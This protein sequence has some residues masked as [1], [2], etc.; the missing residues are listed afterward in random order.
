MSKW[1]KLNKEFYDKLN[2]ITDEEMIS[3]I[4]NQEQNKLKR[5][6]FLEKDIKEHLIE[7]NTFNE[8]NESIHLSIGI[9]KNSQ[10]LYKNNISLISNSVNCTILVSKE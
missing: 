8:I 10:K 6:E 5:I 4:D 9:F 3:W 7:I 2:S 1:D